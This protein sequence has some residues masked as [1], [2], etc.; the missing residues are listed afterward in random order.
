MLK[1]ISNTEAQTQRNEGLTNLQ[2][3]VASIQQSIFQ[4]QQ[5]VTNQAAE[6]VGQNALALQQ[7]V[8]NLEQKGAQDQNAMF[9]F[10]Q[11]NFS[12]LK[13]EMLS[14][15][16]A[17]V[18]IVQSHSSN[19]NW[20]SWVS[21]QLYVPDISQ[22]V[23]NAWWININS[24]HLEI[25]GLDMNG[26]LNQ[27]SI[28]QRG[29]ASVRH[30]LVYFSSLIS[31]Q[32]NL[33]LENVKREASTALVPYEGGS[34]EN[35]EIYE[36]NEEE[37]EEEEEEETIPEPFIP[38]VPQPVPEPQPAPVVP[39]APVIPPQPSPVPTP[40]PQPAPPVPIIPQPPPPVPVVPPQPA[41]AQPQNP[42]VPQFPTAQTPNPS[43][44]KLP[45]VTMDKVISADDAETYMIN[46]QEP[47][48]KGKQYPYEK[49]NN[50]IIP[51]ASVGIKNVLEDPSLYEGLAEN[52]K[53]IMNDI[54]Q[55]V[56]EGNKLGN[57]LK[58]PVPQAV[59]EKAFGIEPWK[60]KDVGGKLEVT[61]PFFNEFKSNSDKYKDLTPRDYALFYDFVSTGV[62]NFIEGNNITKETLNIADDKR[63]LIIS[64]FGAPSVERA[65]ESGVMEQTELPN[66]AFT[67]FV[68]TVLD[69]HG[70]FISPP[71]ATKIQNVKQEFFT[72]R[73]KTKLLP[74]LIE[75][76]NYIL[77]KAPSVE[78][79]T[80]T[81]KAYRA[82]KHFEEAMSDVTAY[83]DATRRY[84]EE[85][86][87][88]QTQK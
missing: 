8:Q 65:N 45:E 64:L 3:V 30:A 9:L 62:E 53:R 69:F 84:N 4:S 43:L 29:V 44:P 34:S 85:K 70:K 75:K 46:G 59:F 77:Q 47:K 52:D 58:Y 49:I 10:A 56:K 51:A 48:F 42:E 39:P 6:V 23:L 20:N 79:N 5:T 33:L 22:N 15:I 37:E 72:L 26:L 88:Y 55:Y 12:S 7:I 54:F 41:P 24:K 19:P 78:A 61:S 66:F 21:Q 16:S 60:I 57:Y 50:I 40:E 31:A 14:G 35:E 36:G 73:D 18:Q 25:M 74:L 67:D 68:R 80:P 63:K 82:K 13:E 32:T 28:L 17:L 86:S 87:K 71:T 11:T 38:P 1:N 76:L 2:A 81:A 27:N 83:E